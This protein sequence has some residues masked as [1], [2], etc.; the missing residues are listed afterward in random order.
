MDPEVK[1]FNMPVSM[2]ISNIG[3]EVARAIRYKKKGDMQK[4]VNFCN[5][6]IDF[7]RLSL[8]DPKNIH[9][10]NEFECAI[11]ELQD[12]FI[13]NNDYQTTDEMLTRYYDAFLTRL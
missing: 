13:G 4:A 7:W 5:K 8:K 1:W 12:Y 10:I 9:R 2:Q 6:A 11:D 3:S